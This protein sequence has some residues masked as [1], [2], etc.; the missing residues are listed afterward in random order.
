M[1]LS[2]SKLLAV[3]WPKYDRTVEKLYIEE[4]EIETWP[5]MWPPNLKI[6]NLNYNI[7]RSWPKKWPKQLTILELENNFLSSWPTSWP[8]KLE[9]LNVEGN[10]FTTF[11]I[12]WPKKLKNINLSGNPIKKISSIPEDSVSIQMDET[13]VKELDN[14]SIYMLCDYLINN[15][16][17][18]NNVTIELLEQ[19][20][21]PTEYRVHNPIGTVSVISA[22]G[23]MH[24]KKQIAQSLSKRIGMVHIIRVENNDVYFVLK[25]SSHDTMLSRGGKTRKG[26][27]RK[28]HKK[29][30]NQSN[31]N[32]RT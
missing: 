16:T 7:L 27:K 17:Q 6:L 15:P 29:K 2:D 11:P 12:I 10:R 26:T 24:L 4:N 18:T 14:D 31:N 32:K 9:F 22:L 3:N 19:V 28:K 8:S 30:S 21:T 13:S 20:G 23:L 25:V 5:D 1:S